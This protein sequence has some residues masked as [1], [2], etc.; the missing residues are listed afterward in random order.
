MPLTGM[1]SL[2]QGAS[3]L[4][5]R[6][7]DL[8]TTWYSPNDWAKWI[9]RCRV[10]TKPTPATHTLRPD[11]TPYEGLGDLMRLATSSRR[12]KEFAF[13]VV[14]M[15]GARTTKV[16]LRRN[17]SGQMARVASPRMD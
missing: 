16:S 11:L 10:R 6:L 1:A 12:L 9:A 8:S 17:G 2:A 5:Q 4:A 14:D 13:E 15:G 3:A 7:N